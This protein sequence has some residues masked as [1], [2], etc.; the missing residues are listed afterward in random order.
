MA[1]AVVASGCALFAAPEPIDPTAAFC[2][3]LDDYAVAVVDF[4]RL[5][6]SNTI[7]EYKAAAQQVADAFEG[8]VEAGAQMREAEVDELD[9]ATDA[10]VDTVNNLPQDVPV[11]EIQQELRSEVADIAAARLSLGVAVCGEPGAAPSAGAS[12]APSAAAS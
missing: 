7:D 11:S 6:E 1:V 3:A 8:V 9:A 4:N 5:D 2:D 12:T 10:L